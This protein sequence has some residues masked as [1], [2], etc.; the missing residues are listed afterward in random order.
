MAVGQC[1]ESVQVGAGGST[2]VD[3]D[4]MI[5]DCVGRCSA[6]LL[7]SVTTAP[8]Y[9]CQIPRT[10]NLSRFH[11]RRDTSSSLLQLVNTP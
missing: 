11:H 2:M 5:T 10:L 9:H 6:L 7:A 1:L 3:T 4:R 8:R